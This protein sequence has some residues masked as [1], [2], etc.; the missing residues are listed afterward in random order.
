MAPAAV[1][2]QR[3]GEAGLGRPTGGERMHAPAAALPL[4]PRRTCC[5]ARAARGL[6]GEGT[7]AGGGAGAASGDDALRQ[8]EEGRGRRAAAAADAVSADRDGRNAPRRRGGR[9]QPPRSHA[10]H[11]TAAGAQKTHGSQQRDHGTPAGFRG[12]RLPDVPSVGLGAAATG[13]PLAVPPARTLRPAA[14]S[15]VCERALASLA[16]SASTS[17]RQVPQQRQPRRLGAPP[18]R[19]RAVRRQLGA[20]VRAA[21]GS[22]VTRRCAAAAAARSPGKPQ[23]CAAFDAPAA[24]AALGNYPYASRRPLK[25]CGLSHERR[26]PPPLP[27]H[28]AAGRGSASPG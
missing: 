25:G 22:A 1:A 19:S 15:M 21:A 18:R 8:V 13:A 9:F 2:W 26:L 27:S 17:G 4:H 10:A 12:E 5:G 3:L 23:L 16:G 28:S 11:W 6:L 24:C 7:R 20:V 14:A